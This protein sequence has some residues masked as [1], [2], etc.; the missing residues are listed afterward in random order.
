MVASLDPGKEFIIP[1]AFVGTY[2]GDL[3]A[4]GNSLRKYLFRHAIPE[5]LRQ[6]IRRCLSLNIRSQRQDNLLRPLSVDPRQ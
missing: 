1:P 4:M 2:A 5:Q 3:D 6:V